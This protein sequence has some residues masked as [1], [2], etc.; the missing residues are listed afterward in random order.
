M[1]V[2]IPAGASIRKGRSPTNAKARSPR[3]ATKSDKKPAVEL[4]VVKPKTKGRSPRTLRGV[5]N[6]KK[7]GRDGELRVLVLLFAALFWTSGGVTS[8]AQTSEGDMLYGQR[9]TACHSPDPGDIAGRSLVLLDGRIVTRRSGLELRAHLATHA[10]LQGAEME[11][12]IS[13]L[14]NEVGKQATQQ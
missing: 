11:A 12:I 1:I 9:C 6:E 13:L 10:Q 5:R 4:K 2:P 7:S 14:Q 3:R 8:Y